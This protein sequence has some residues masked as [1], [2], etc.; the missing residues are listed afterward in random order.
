MKALWIALA[1]YSRLPAPRTAWEEKDMAWALCWFP[2]VGLAAAGLLRLWCAL[3]AWLEIDRA[4]AAEL[5][6]YLRVL[7]CTPRGR[8][9]LGRMRRT[10]ALPVLTKPA[11]VKILS[12]LAQKQFRREAAA[13]ERYA[14][15][16]PSLAEALPAQ[17]WRSR[18]VILE[19]EAPALQEEL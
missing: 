5:P 11:D 3:C 17:E 18:P 16:F 10:A 9:I 1:M 14:L 4:A 8:E 7:G 6:A 12:P 13:T 15:L 19:S 2:V